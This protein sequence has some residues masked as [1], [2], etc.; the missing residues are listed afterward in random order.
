MTYLMWKRGHGFRVGTS[1]TYTDGRAQPLPGP[2]FRMNQ[3][4]ADAAWVLATHETEA[5]ARVAELLTLASA[6]PPDASFRRA[7]E[8]AATTGAAS[9]ATRSSSTSIFG[10]LDTETRGRAAPRPKV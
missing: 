4:H 10:E 9:S 8:R 1:R 7:S 3:E 5:D 6:R 2:A